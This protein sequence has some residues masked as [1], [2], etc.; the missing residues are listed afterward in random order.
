M[1]YIKRLATILLIALN[2]NCYSQWIKTNAPD[3]CNVFCFTNNGQNLFAGADVYGILKLSDDMLNWNIM[4]K[5]ITET[6]VQSIAAYNSVF[7]A[8]ANGGVFISTNNGTSWDDISNGIANPYITTTAIKDS[9]FFIGNTLGEIYRSTDF[10]KSWVIV[11]NAPKYSGLI[12]VLGISGNNIIMGIFGGDNAYRGIYLSTDNGIN[13]NQNNSFGEIRAMYINNNEV[14]IATDYYV[15]YS[16]DNG[17][18]WAELSQIDYIDEIILYNNLLFV[19]DNN[20]R[21]LFSN[22]NNINWNTLNPEQES[23]PLTISMAIKDSYLFAGTSG[24]GIWRKPIANILSLQTKNIINRYELEQ[25]YPNPFNSGTI[26]P[27]SIPQKGNVE[28]IIYDALGR[29][30]KELIN[31]VKPIGNYEIKFNAEAL[32]SGVYFYQIKTSKFIQTKKM[33][34]LR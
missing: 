11:K 31:E 8:G 17:L 10:G 15:Y 30:C 24:Y 33:L 5:G 14:F 22:K 21:I 13:W 34:L 4:N 32:T 25:N 1:F 23:P 12:H 20:F 27:Y 28:I 3:S 19:L 16:S 18:N 2:S 26:I 9:T 7:L 6:Y 29:K